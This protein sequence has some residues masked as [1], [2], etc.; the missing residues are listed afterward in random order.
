MHNNT[1]MNC[2]NKI[3]SRALTGLHCKQRQDDALHRQIRSRFLQQSA[4]Y[5]GADLN[6]NKVWYLCSADVSYIDI[7]ANQ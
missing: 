2:D 5:L 1:N 3:T 4:R 7:N 6:D